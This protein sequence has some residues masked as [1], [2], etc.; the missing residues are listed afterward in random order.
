MPNTV[1]EASTKKKC[2]YAMFVLV[3]FKSF[4]DLD[5]LIGCAECLDEQRWIDTYEQWIPQCSELTRAFM[6]N[7]ADYYSGFATAKLRREAAVAAKQ[8]DFNVDYDDTSTDDNDDLFVADDL[9][10]VDALKEDEESRRL[11]Q[12]WELEGGPDTILESSTLHP[13]ACPTSSNPDRK[14]AYMMDL[15]KSREMVRGVAEN[16][17]LGPHSTLPTS[18]LPPIPSTRKWITDFHTDNTLTLSLDPTTIPDH[19]TEAVELLDISLDGSGMAWQP[20]PALSHDPRVVEIFAKESYDSGETL[21]LVRRDSQLLMFLGVKEVQGSVES[22]RP[23][24]LRKLDLFRESASNKIGNLDLI[25][26]DEV[27]MKK[28]EFLTFRFGVHVVL[29]GDVLQ[30]PP[31][32]ENRC[33]KPLYKDKYVSRRVRWL[34]LWCEFQNVEIL[35]DLVRFKADPEWGRD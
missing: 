22:F 8:G 1:G 7:M 16:L 23:G 26:I 14:I 12:T 4:Q 28:N 9:D 10:G 27:S 20:S 3:L 17:T 21:I 29:V 31:V 15:F 24:T 11:L 35:K 32:G 13:A 5:D 6:D 33:K 30:L 2:K 34:S 25:I 18:V 19:C